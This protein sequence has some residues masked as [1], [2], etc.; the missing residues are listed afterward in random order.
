MTLPSPPILSNS[1]DS[2]SDTKISTLNLELRQSLLNLR[3]IYT[4]L[5]VLKRDTGL[6]ICYVTEANYIDAAR[7]SWKRYLEE[8]SEDEDEFCSFESEVLVPTTFVVVPHLPRN[9]CVEWQVLVFNREYQKQAE[10]EIDSS[11]EEDFDDDNDNDNYGDGKMKKKRVAPK[12]T[13]ERVHI[14]ANGFHVEVYSKTTA[15]IKT[16]VLECSYSGT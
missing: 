4:A 10:F 8:F 3:A 12:Y 9:A 16:L 6:C 11:D 7:K 13:S 2:D 1:T 5:K 15:S 14:E